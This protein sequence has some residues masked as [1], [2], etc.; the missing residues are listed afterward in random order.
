MFDLSKLTETIGGLVSGAQQQP[1]ADGS[2]LAGLL[3]NAG[4]DPGQ[5]AG[6]TQGE[7]VEQLQQYGIDPAQ[8]DL[9]Q[10]SELA[11]NAD[12]GGNLAEIA[13]SWLASRR[14]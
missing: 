4:I 2:G 6:L 3:I 5:L 13:Q 1:P 12:I 14:S 7:I 11:A 8:L 9:G 10:I